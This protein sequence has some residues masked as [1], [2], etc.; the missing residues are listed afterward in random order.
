M[1]NISDCF[2]PNRCPI[3][4]NLLYSST[5]SLVSC[6]WFASLSHQLNICLAK[7]FETTRRQTVLTSLKWT[8]VVQERCDQD[9]SQGTKK[10]QHW[11]HSWRTF[12]PGWNQANCSEPV[13]DYKISTMKSSK[14]SFTELQMLRLHN[15]NSFLTTNT[16]WQ[17]RIK[18]EILW[19]NN[20]WLFKSPQ[21]PW[22]LFFF[23]VYERGSRGSCH[24]LFYAL[25]HWV[26]G[27]QNWTCSFY[28][29]ENECFV[30]QQWFFGQDCRCHM[31][32][33]KRK[34]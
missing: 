11:N 24:F 31:P 22:T 29:L 5:S 34:K 25:L 12:S 14:W 7:G 20:M 23:G 19:P 13:N 17:T 3:R 21:G 15:G 16:K 27:T 9:R 28:Q 18:T 2:D 8:R 33:P 1:D 26:L 32:L 30:F 4:V 6:F 10:A